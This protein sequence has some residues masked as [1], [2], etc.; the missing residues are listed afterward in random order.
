MK[1]LLL[2]VLA[3]LITG[4]IAGPY[5][6]RAYER[7]M[8]PA[9]DRLELVAVEFAGLPGWTNDNLN[10]FLPAFQ[11]SC[12][13]F[14]RWRPERRLGPEAWAGTAG[15]WLDVCAA[16]ARAAPAADK[17]GEAAR[18]FAEQ[19]FRPFQVRN[20][21]RQSGL[22][23]GYYEPELRGSL[24]RQGAYQSALLR[25]PAGLVS[26]NLGEFNA[27]WRGRRI[28]G[29]IAG[30]A[31]KPLQPR[32]AIEAG[33]LKNEKL[34]LLYVDDPVDAFFMHIQGSGRVRLADGTVLRLGYD[35]Q[36]GHP[37]VAI[38]KALIDAG[39]MTREN[40]SMQSLR[41]WLAAHP[42]RRD[43]ILNKNPSYVFFREI[44]IA[45]PELGPFGAQGQPLTPGRS[46][47]VDLDFHPLGV[48]VWLDTVA[49]DAKD[50]AT[51]KLQRLMVA[52][53]TGGAIKGPV[54]GDVFWGF[55]ADA[56]A[57]AGRMNSQ[58]QMFVLLPHSVAQSMTGETKN[59][60]AR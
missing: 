27:E 2:A 58:G 3:S 53:D 55:G 34:E 6:Q 48:P 46:L 20:N 32:A 10:D 25:R 4:V 52:Q 50:G 14:R 42:E 43:E 51:S 36:N 18:R 54:R 22:F 56:G 28:A 7:L 17:S 31:L 29:R 1:R 24:T 9:P 40:V 5:L 59:N 45:E 41:A 15:D 23:T 8:A 11:R 26:V 33:A 60:A 57:I 35:G 47:A 19:N 21:R 49:P 16:A 13:V 37:Y 30:G 12:K 38:G 39:E 44:R